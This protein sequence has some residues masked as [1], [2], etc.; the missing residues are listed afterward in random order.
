MIL[1]SSYTSKEEIPEQYRDLFT[2]KKDQEGNEFWECTEIEGIKTQGDVDRVRKALNNEKE[3]HAE[4]KK[5]LKAIETERNEANDKVTALEADDKKSAD[6]KEIILEN[7]RLKRENEK[8][9]GD[10]TTTA[11]ELTGIKTQVVTGKIEAALRKA[12]QGIVRD[13]AIEH[14]TQELSKNFIISDGEVLTRT[15]LG[16]KSGLEP[17]GF[18][19]KIVKEQPWLVP[20]STSGGAQGGTKKSGTAVTDDDKPESFEEMI[21]E[22]S[23][24]A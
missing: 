3:E 9:T 6:Q 2:Q 17:K 16:D 14:A 22:P 12:A 19:E 7:Q 18:L 5:N 4:T 11:D 23:S 8:L 1:K 15:D 10:L 21:P 20:A 24:A 13:D